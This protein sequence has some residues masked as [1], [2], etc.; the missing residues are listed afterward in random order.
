[1]DWRLAKCAGMNLRP[2]PMIVCSAFVKITLSM[3][4]TLVLCSCNFLISICSDC[5]DCCCCCSVGGCSIDV[6]GFSFL[7]L[8]LFLDLG[9]FENDWRDSLNGSDDHESAMTGCFDWNS[10]IVT[11]L[12]NWTFGDEHG[13]VRF[14]LDEY[15]LC[16]ALICFL[17]SGDAWGRVL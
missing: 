5:D 6:L 13:G 14:F 9:F 15:F 11:V 8:F 2:S 7:C 12:W 1:M 3:L 17:R 4:N 10:W 16:H